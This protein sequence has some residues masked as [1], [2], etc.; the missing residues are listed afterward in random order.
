MLLFRPFTI[1]GKTK[2]QFALIIY[3]ILYSKCKSTKYMNEYIM[4]NFQLIFADTVIPLFPH[5]II[6]LDVSMV[7][8]KVK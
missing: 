7:Y 4:K 1:S 3:Y 8:K 6:F 2:T 5:H